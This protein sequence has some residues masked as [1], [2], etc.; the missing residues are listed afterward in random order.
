VLLT[1]DEAVRDG[2]MHPGDLV[3]MLAIGAGMAWAA[4]LYRV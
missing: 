3:V 4:A 1:F 2:R